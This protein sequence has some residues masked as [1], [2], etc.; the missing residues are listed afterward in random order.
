MA[1]QKKE[2]LMMEIDKAKIKIKEIKI[3]CLS[4]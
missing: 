3:F 1:L 2:F 4:K